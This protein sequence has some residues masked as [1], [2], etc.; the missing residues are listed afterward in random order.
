[1]MLGSPKIV[2]IATPCFHCGETC[3]DTVLEFQNHTFCCNGCKTVYEILEGAD[4]NCY[5]DIEASPGIRPK[6]IAGD[7]E[8]LELPEVQK[9]IIQFEDDEIYKLLLSI[10]QVHCSSCIYLL[11]QLHEIN[12]A[13]LSSRVNFQRKEITLTV[14]KQPNILYD[15]FHLLNKIGYTPQIAQPEKPNIS[16]TSKRLIIKIGV[17]G[18]CFGNIM[19]LSFPDY[20]S[21]NS[22][23]ED[24][25][26]HVFNYLIVLFILPVLFY[27]ASDYF[28][29]A[30]QNLK[31]KNLSVDVPIV[32][33]ILALFTRSIYEIFLL[34]Q[35]GYFDSL[36]GFIF[37]LLIGKW[38][39]SRT[40]ENLSFN[41]SYSSFFPLAVLRKVKNEYK[42]T[43][44]KDL[45]EGDIIQLRNREILPVN[46]QLLD[47]KAS[48]DYSFVTGES[49]TITKKQKEHL[50]AGGKL[51][52]ATAQLM[53]TEAV[54]QA[55]LQDLWNTV[56]T[57]KSDKKITNII[58]AVSQ[59]FTLTIVVIAIFGFFFWLFYADF[60][61]A[62]EVFTAILIVAC[63][64]ALALAAP[65]TYGNASRIFSNINV[66]LK[67]TSIVERLSKIKQLVFDKTGTLTQKDGAEVKFMGE[68]LDEY[69]QKAIRSIV[70]CSLHPL[71][72]TLAEHLTTSASLEVLNFEEVD[73]KGIKAIL[74]GEDYV[75]GSMSWLIQN[76]VD[77]HEVQDSQR[78]SVHI[79]KNH[80]YLGYFEFGNA[81]RNQLLEQIKQL[82]KRY[83]ISILSG[84][85]NYEETFLRQQLESVITLA[86]HQSPEQ[87][88][89]FIQKLKSNTGEEVM[90]L[91]DGINDAIALKA[92]DIGVAI[93]EDTGSFTPNSDIIMHANSLVKLPQILQ[94]GKDCMHVLYMCL[95]V[96][97]LYNLIGLGFAFSGWLT[98]LVAAILMPLSSI[99]VVMVAVGFTN[100]FA[101]KRKIIS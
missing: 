63:P 68:N 98:P 67:E 22:I 78:S 48:F 9:Q 58:D 100:Y 2:Q 71:S 49:K 20:I 4:L 30:Y 64:C 16:A 73:G 51:T 34:G 50:F 76:G 26:E 45:K 19:L 66:Y 90:M 28:K 40:Y 72:K 70:S 6:P 44:I 23:I 82:G 1:M 27:A 57:S 87:K 46:A 10:P 80:I 81:Y 94:Y 93:T 18:F 96:S 95:M 85:G 29:A 42:T 74:N 75:I 55:Y 8:F 47:E 41:K 62:L 86:F 31:I 52:S 39:Q 36:A 3:K 60:N 101:R 84:D 92:S 37:F 77:L 11:E 43:N 15:T 5:Y 65:F 13:I 35:P 59:R 53:V 32:L 24:Q 14:K 56:P 88:E 21:G 83:Q 38:F 54:N 7:F 12:A 33:G 17:A 99:T 69:T 25:F 61:K 79:A 97:L 89:A 91:G